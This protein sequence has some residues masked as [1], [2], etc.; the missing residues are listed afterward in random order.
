MEDVTDFRLPIRHRPT[1]NIDLDGVEQASLDK[2]I[3]SSNIGFKLLQKMGWKGKGLGKAEQGM[4]FIPFLEDYFCK[5]SQNLYY[6]ARV[7]L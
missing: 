7:N 3:S 4:I 1:E 6:L 5:G 2:H